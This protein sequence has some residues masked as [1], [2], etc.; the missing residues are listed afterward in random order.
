MWAFMRDYRLNL[1]SVGIAPAQATEAYR[2]SRVVAPTILRLDTR[3]KK[4]DS[5]IR[6]E[7]APG[8]H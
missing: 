6:D 8:F 4:V 1:P 5:F 7:R 3:R 2:G